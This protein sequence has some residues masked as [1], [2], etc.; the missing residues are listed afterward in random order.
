MSAS[1]L[2]CP[3]HINNDCSL[4]LTPRPNDAEATYQCIMDEV[5]ICM[6]MRAKEMGYPVIQPEEPTEQR[7]KK[8]GNT[9]T[10]TIKNDTLNLIH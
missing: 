2:N 1:N 8:R 5:E 7:R 3:T 9:G 10:Y 4:I 6:D